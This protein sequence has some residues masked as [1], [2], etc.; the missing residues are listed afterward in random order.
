[1]RR[2]KGAG[3]CGAP[4][5]RRTIEG[6]RSRWATRAAASAILIAGLLV[7]SAHAIIVMRNP[8]RNTSPPTGDV[9]EAG[10]QYE[11]DW[12]HFTGTVVGPHH[13]LTAAHVGGLPLQA[14]RYHG[15]DYY[16]LEKAVIPNTDI[17]LWRVAGTFP[18][19]ATLYEGHSEVG[20]D[21]FVCGCGGP[22][23]NP[24]VVHGKTVGWY[25]GGQDGVLSWG[26]NRISDTGPG[27]ADARQPV[28]PILTFHFDRDTSGAGDD[29]A[30]FSGGDSG[31][32]VFL[33]DNDGK[34]RLAGINYG[35]DRSYY[36]GPEDKYDIPAAIF[37]ARGLYRNLPTGRYYLDPLESYKFP[38]TCL[39][40]RL[41]PFVLDLK[42]AMQ[43]PPRW[44][45]YLFWCAIFAGVP[46]AAGGIFAFTQRRLTHR[47]WLKT[48]KQRRAE[49]TEDHP[50][51]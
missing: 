7:G 30:C 48:R 5:P 40:S 1:M 18:S 37:D 2:R 45:L 4:T 24:L 10:W 26:R 17:A 19:W 36:L 6:T 41:S 11:G 8:G 9:A 25:M 39:V 46:F 32:G 16:A 12:H 49:Q 20:K 47:L 43:R 42:V 14:F 22:R 44:K 21:V 33:H 31:G 15:H 51:E 13:F 34:W 35:I 23:G 28:G 29:T 50:A 38:T 27:H 3:R